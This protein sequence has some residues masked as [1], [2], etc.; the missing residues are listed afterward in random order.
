MRIKHDPIAA[1][2][3]Q[4]HGLGLGADDGS[5]AVHVAGRHRLLLLQQLEHV[6]QH[7]PQHAVLV[8]QLQGLAV[9]PHIAKQRRGLL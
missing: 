9:S 6:A 3:G 5:D 1:Q 2:L 8:H 4:A 7:G